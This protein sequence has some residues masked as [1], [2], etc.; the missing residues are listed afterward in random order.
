MLIQIIQTGN[1]FLQYLRSRN[2]KHGIIH[3]SCK[4][5]FPF[6]HLCKVIHNFHQLAVFAETR[7]MSVFHFFDGRE[8]PLRNDIENF[9][10][11]F[12]LKFAPAHR[13]PD[14]RLGK[15]LVHR[16]TGHIF[17]FFVFQFLFIQRTDKH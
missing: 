8:Y 12:V 5:G 11:V 14:C 15:Y 2:Q 6:I 17:K 9:S 13:L 10:G 4:G 3:V 16:L 1:D 7:Q